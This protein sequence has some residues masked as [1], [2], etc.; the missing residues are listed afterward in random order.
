MVHEPCAQ[1]VRALS[2]HPSAYVHASRGQ[3][4]R[5]LQRALRA[6]S[7]GAHRAGRALGTDKP[8]PPCARARI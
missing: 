7:A 4:M 3:R 1:R 5:H 2:L 8:M 6:V